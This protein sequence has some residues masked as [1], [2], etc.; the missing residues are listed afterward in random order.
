MKRTLLAISITIASTQA[1]ATNFDI[2]NPYNHVTQ[3]QLKETN[4]NLVDTAY[5]ANDARTK[6][7]D[8]QNSANLGIQVGE[9]AL[10]AASTVQSNLDKTN[11]NVSNLN[12]KVDSYAAHGATAYNEIKGVQNSQQSQLNNVQDA[13]QQAN[14]K[15]DSAHVRLDSVETNLGN[16]QT[17]AQIA[18]DRANSLESRTDVSENAIRETNGAV[19]SVNADLQSSK[20]AGVAIATGLNDKIDSVAS[21]GAAEFTKTNNNVKAVD[22]KVNT[23][24]SVQSGIN[25]NQANT[26]TQVQGQLSSVQTSAQNAQS[27]ANVALSVGVSNTASIAKNT[28]DIQVTNEFVA[29]QGNTLSE[30]TAQ[31]RSN[32]NNIVTLND[33]Q[34][35]HSVQLSSNTKQLSNHETRITNIEDYSRDM[36]TRL[37]GRLDSQ[38]SEIRGLKRDVNKVGN[39]AVGALAVAGHQFSTDYQAGPQVALSGATMGGYHAVAVGFGGAVSENVFLNAAFTS[40]GS[41]TGAVVS[42]TYRLK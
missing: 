37:S 19:S 18:N 21:Q 11:T 14:V 16:V 8:A 20:A 4:K 32:T 29:A 34:Q 24:I 1:F 5:V 3:S 35:Q 30:H 25:A 26:N 23:A 36:D 2:T 6:A 42:G 41:Q 39:I 28:N 9:S 7:F 12:N 38:Q 13:A 27:T 10:K 17:A 31:I 33:V 22:D 15:A 40:A